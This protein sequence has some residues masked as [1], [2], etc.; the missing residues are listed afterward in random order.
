VKKVENE[1]DA[2]FSD[3][4]DVFASKFCPFSHLSSKMKVNHAFKAKKEAFRERN[5]RKV[6]NGPF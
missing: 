5:L 4:Y 2:T 3:V 6:E 1:T